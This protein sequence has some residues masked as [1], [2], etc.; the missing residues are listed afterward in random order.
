MRNYRTYNESQKKRGKMNFLHIFWNVY[1]EYYKTNRDM[2][3]KKK[4]REKK[5]PIEWEL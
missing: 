1:R 3:L 4:K 2:N 5:N